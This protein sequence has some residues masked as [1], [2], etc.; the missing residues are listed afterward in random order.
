MVRHHLEDYLGVRPWTRHS[1][2]LLVAGL[3]Y[4]G[5]GFSYVYANETNDTNM[6]AIRLAMKWMPLDYWG[7]VWIVVGALAIISARWPPISKTWGYS[8]MT[9]MS[10]AWAAMYVIGVVVLGGPLYQINGV[11][12]WGTLAFMWWAISGLIA[13]EERVS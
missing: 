8:A 2:V 3:A 11:F 10:A 9:G 13:P 12:V 7:A 6:T 4:I 1:L 5:I